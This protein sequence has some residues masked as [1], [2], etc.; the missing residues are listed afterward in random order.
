MWSLKCLHVIKIEPDQHT[1]RSMDDKI[2][3]SKYVKQ[4]GGAGHM[5]FPLIHVFFFFIVLS[6]NRY[7]LPMRASLAIYLTCSVR[8]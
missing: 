5:P 8:I 3:I 2:D 1:I 4:V 7:I 6:G